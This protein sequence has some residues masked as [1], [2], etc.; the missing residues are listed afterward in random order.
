MPFDPVSYALGT[1]NGGGGG[2]SVTVE[3]LSVTSNGTTT[4]PTGKAYSPV[5][6]NVPNTYA[7]GDEGKV[8]SNGALVA[9]TTHAEVTQNGTVDT[10]L[11]NSVTVNVPNSYTAGDEGKVVSNGALVAQAAHAEVTQNGTVDTTYNNSVVVNVSGGG[12]TEVPSNDVNFI[13]YDGTIVAAYSAADFAQLSAL[14]ANPSHSGLTAQGWNWTLADAKTYVAAN[15]MCDIG[16]MYVT[17]DGKTRLYIDIDADQLNYKIMFQQSPA[18]CITVDWGDESTA[19]TFSGA[20]VTATHT[21]TTAG[22]YIITLAVAENGDLKLGYTGGNS[23]IVGYVGSGNSSNFTM[24]KTLKKVEIG[25]GVSTIYKYCFSGCVNMETITIPNLAISFG[26]YC[27]QSATSLKCLVLPAQMSFYIAPSAFAGYCLS[28]EHICIPNITLG[29][30]SQT[31]GNFLE[32]AYKLKRLCYSSEILSS[33]FLTYA[34]S[35]KMILIPTSVTTINQQAMRYNYGVEAIKFCSSSPPTISNSS[36]FQYLPTS[37]KIYVPTGSLS[38][39]TSAANYPS[40]S[41]YTYVEY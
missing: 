32:R 2:S 13:D 39:Y 22:S 26:E 21:Y 11:N 1:K 35:M 8:V 30:A 34:Y 18:E 7:A 15:G 20:V 29:T 9:Q 40:S 6:V 33:A 10:T 5:V 31:N 28:L 27:F 23:A 14:P 16:Q 36:A 3:P 25:T 12:G 41:T 17:S 38:S 4:A 24:S 19:E 37:C